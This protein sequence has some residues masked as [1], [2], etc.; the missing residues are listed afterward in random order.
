M[1]AGSSQISGSNRLYD[2]P[3][4]ENDGTNFQTWK[5]WIS[6]VF[7][8]RGL[9]GIV[10][11]TIKRP[12]LVQLADKSTNQSDINDWDRRDMEAQAQLTLTLKDE[13]LSGVLHAT[14]A[15]D[16]WDK[17]NCHYEGKGQ[18]CHKPPLRQL[19]SF[20]FLFSS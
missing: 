11:G 12:I 7:R 10:D 3:S 9:M 16:V 20:P 15:A 6:T 1:S 2:I 13:P 5:Y 14:L 19:S 18:N 4:L 8:L 17:L